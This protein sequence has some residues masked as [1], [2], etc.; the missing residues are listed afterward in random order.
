LIALGATGAVLAPLG[1]PLH[2]NNRVVAKALVQALAGGRRRFC[3][4]LDAAKAD[5][6]ALEG[7][8][9]IGDPALA[10]VAAAGATRR[11]KSVFAPA[12]DAD[13]AASAEDHVLKRWS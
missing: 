11:G 6:A 4:I 2:E 5:G 7:Y 9:V 12:A 3:D 8:A 1:D 10:A 13:L